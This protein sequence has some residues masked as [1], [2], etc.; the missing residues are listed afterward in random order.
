MK[1]SYTAKFLLISADSA[2][3]DGLCFELMIGISEE[4]VKH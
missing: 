3:F 1:T 4:L 2:K